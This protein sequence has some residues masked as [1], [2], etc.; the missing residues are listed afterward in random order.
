VVEALAAGLVADAGLR[1]ATCW[2]PVMFQRVQIRYEFFE[3]RLT[4]NESDYVAVDVG[5][6]LA[7][8]GIAA[9]LRRFYAAFGGKE[10]TGYMLF[11]AEGGLMKFSATGRGLAYV[12]ADGPLVPVPPRP[13]GPLLTARLRDAANWGEQQAVAVLAYVE[14][15][16][17][18]RATVDET[19]ALLNRMTDNLEYWRE[20]RSAADHAAK[21]ERARRDNGTGNA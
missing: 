20:L 18:G 1:P 16:R 2:R 3:Q 9:L 17:S 6:G 8:T 11:P 19:A 5:G 14:M 15:L 4:R 12:A 7:G 21:E 10:H 13:P